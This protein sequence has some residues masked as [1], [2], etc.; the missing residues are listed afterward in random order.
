MMKTI[1]AF[2]LL[3]SGIGFSM[4]IY[5]ETYA[6]QKMIPQLEKGNR[7]TGSSPYEAMEHIVAVPMNANIRK[8]LGTGD[9]SIHFIDSDGNTVKAGPEDYII[10]PRSLS[11][12]Y[13]LS[14]RHLQEYYRGQ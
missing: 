5:P 2:F 14:K 12:I 1:A 13:V 6:M 10:A 8:A 7:Y 3:V 11:R 9:S 4:E